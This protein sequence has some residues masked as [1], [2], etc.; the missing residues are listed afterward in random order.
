MAR[1]VKTLERIKPM[2][3]AAL[4]WDVTISCK[5]HEFSIGMKP[6]R[7][8]RAY[9]NGAWRQSGIVQCCRGLPWLYAW[10]TSQ[11]L[12][13]LQF[14]FVRKGGWGEQTWDGVIIPDGIRFARCFNPLQG[15]EKFMAFRQLI[16][17]IGSQHLKKVSLETPSS[18]NQVEIYFGLRSE[19]DG[20]LK[21]SHGWL[22]GKKQ[23]KA[24]SFGREQEIVDCF[25]QKRR[26]SD[27][28]GSANPMKRFC[29][30]LRVGTM[31]NC[32]I[33]RRDYRVKRGFRTFFHKVSSILSKSL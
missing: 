29:E 4:Q 15:E 11:V 33:S 28:I 30:N 32:G 22:E 26:S 14:G 25:V 1:R 9:L 17:L 19:M 6:W 23:S 13:T 2:R 8:M 10:T 12:N 21:R 31:P 7:W 18:S 5:V 3:A 24:Q 20:S 16:L 27:W